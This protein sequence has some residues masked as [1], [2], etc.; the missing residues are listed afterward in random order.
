VRHL[1]SEAQSDL[2]NS[3]T[4]VMV[5]LQPDQLAAL[6]AWIA[7]QDVTVSRPEAIRAI[8]QE[9]A[10]EDRRRAHSPHRNRH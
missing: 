9:K 3:E 10:G 2:A 7:A 5:R 8:L 4:P 6:D 1:I